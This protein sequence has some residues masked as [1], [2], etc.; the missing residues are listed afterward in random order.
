MLF[1]GLSVAKASFSFGHNLASSSETLPKGQVTAGSY[2]LGYGVTDRFTIATS[3]WLYM[4]YNMNNMILRHSIPVNADNEIGQQLAY[5][6]TYKTPTEAYIMR[7]ASYS[8]TWKTVV[9]PSYNL[10]VCAN[11]MYFWNEARPFSLRRE[12]YNDLPYQYSI[13]TLHQFHISK[14]FLTQFEAGILGLNYTYPFLHGGA[15]LGYF[16]KTFSYQIGASVSRV[17]EPNHWQKPSY[18]D[19]PAVEGESTEA[20]S[21]HPEVQLQAWF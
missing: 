13:S 2:A 4:G 11:Y 7:A 9:D 10:Y 16:G 17:G 21:V 1:M 15:S 6:D 19:G 3:P 5:F 18:T 20:M 12:P 8:L 14:N